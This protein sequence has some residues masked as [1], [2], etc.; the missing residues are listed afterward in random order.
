[1]AQWKLE[2][3]RSCRLWDLLLDGFG[4]CNGVGLLDVC[5]AYQIGLIVYGLQSCRV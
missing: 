4:V 2:F 1:M 3:E 5:W